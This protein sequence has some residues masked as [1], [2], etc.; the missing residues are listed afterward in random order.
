MNRKWDALDVFH[1]Y[2]QS[3]F[4]QW[5]NFLNVMYE[6]SDVTGI[7]KTIYG[8]N[9]GMTDLV[10]TSLWK[11]LFET[12]A[13]AVLSQKSSGSKDTPAS[14]EHV[15][16]T[17]LRMQRSLEDTAKRIFRDKNPHPNDHPLKKQMNMIKSKKERDIKLEEFFRKAR[18]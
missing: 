10:K 8:L 5:N 3:N 1:L 16:E 6:K 9:A 2:A 12:K 4:K 15:T 18:M 11:G 17:Y 13:E 14:R 7:E